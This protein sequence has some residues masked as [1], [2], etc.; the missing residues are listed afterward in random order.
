LVESEHQAAL[1]EKHV[2]EGKFDEYRRYCEKDLRAYERVS[3]ELGE[4]QAEIIKLQEEVNYLE[5]QGQQF[6]K[7]IEQKEQRIAELEQFTRKAVEDSK[8]EAEKKLAN[9]EERLEEQKRTYGNS[10]RHADERAREL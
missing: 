1:K 5:E 7:K 10:S 6:L 3:Q 8:R 4:K 9:L 2:L